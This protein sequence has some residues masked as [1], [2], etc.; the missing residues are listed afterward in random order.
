MSHFIL[1]NIMVNFLIVLFVQGLIELVQE[2]STYTTD[3]G[4]QTA[5]QDHSG[6]QH[7]VEHSIEPE[8]EVIQLRLTVAGTVLVVTEVVMGADDPY[9]PWTE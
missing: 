6:P 3:N 5:S 1:A 9:I 7:E 8:H 2:A 4:P